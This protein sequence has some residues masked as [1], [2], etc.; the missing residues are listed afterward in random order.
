MLPATSSVHQ[1][2]LDKR[3]CDSGSQKQNSLTGASCNEI[4][5]IPRIPLIPTDVPFEFK[6]LQFSVHLAFAITINKSQGQMLTVA[7]VHLAEPCF[8][9]GQLYV[10]LSRVGT[11][12]GLFCK[13][14][15][16]RQQ[17]KE[18][19]LQE[20]VAVA[21]HC[22]P[23]ERFLILSEFHWKGM[24]AIG[25]TN[26][27]AL[28]IGLHLFGTRFSRMRWRLLSIYSA[29]EPIAVSSSSS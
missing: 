19:R 5:F 4:E 22:R 20:C 7:G 16:S 29:R 12:T 28:T 13:Y 6:R 14:C 21:F 3:T 15:Y 2:R 9:H 25:I 27:I 11:P 26:N 8:S 1:S 10:T 18:Y 17:N 23:F 24:F